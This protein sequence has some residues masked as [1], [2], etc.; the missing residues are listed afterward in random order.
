MVVIS[1][2]DGGSCYEGGDSLVCAFG[3]TSFDLY[4]VII[5]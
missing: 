5:V 1:V 3:Y 4:V 2:G